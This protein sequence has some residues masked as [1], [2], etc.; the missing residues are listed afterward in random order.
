LSFFFIAQQWTPLHW[1]CEEGYKDIALLLI[2]HKAD[3]NGKSENVSFRNM[4]KKLAHHS[5]YSKAMDAS[6]SG[7]R[8]GTQWSC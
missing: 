2:E 1:A 3:L 6:P 4:K 5:N 8:K 7:M